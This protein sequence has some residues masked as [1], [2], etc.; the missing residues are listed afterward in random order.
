MARIE[1]TVIRAY[2]EY[3]I[4]KCVLP[5]PVPDLLQLIPTSRSHAQVVREI[6][7]SDHL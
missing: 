7:K 5:L 1:M 4:P 6:H 2:T 3:T